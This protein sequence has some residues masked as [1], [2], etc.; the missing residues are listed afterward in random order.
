MAFHFKQ[1]L[2]EKLVNY[3]IDF[4][5]ALEQDFVKETTYA[6]SKVYVV[7]KMLQDSKIFQDASTQPVQLMILC[8][9]NK[10]QETQTIFNDI[11]TQS[12]MTAYTDLV[13]GLYVK[14]TFTSPVVLNNFNE[15][16]AG[17][18]SLLYLTCSLFIMENIADVTELTIDDVAVQPLGFNL[19]Y[20]MTP[21]T[22]QFNR[23][24]TANYIA[25]SVKNTSGLAVSMSVILKNDTL[26]TKILN[27]LNEVNSGNDDFSISF[28]ISGVSVSKTMKLTAFSVNTA[29]TQIP[30]TQL[31][32]MK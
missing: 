19:S 21:D 7:I 28:K 5:V 9:E 32:F 3:G 12:N 14:F 10:I 6:T 4:E 24:A 15:A 18:R 31:G 22:Q 23:A 13:N 17:Y 26:T 8:E 2:E 30:S 25:T 29:P 16:F 20:T 27:I 11:A 1:W